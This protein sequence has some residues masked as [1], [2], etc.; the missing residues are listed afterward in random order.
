M[1]RVRQWWTLTRLIWWS[2][3]WHASKR[4]DRRRLY[5]RRLVTALAARVALFEEDIE[6]FSPVALSCWLGACLAARSGVRR[7]VG[8]SG[9]KARPFAKTSGIA[10]MAAY[11]A[12]RWMGRDA[13]AEMT[14]EG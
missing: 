7:P 9:R 14:L 10:V 11:Y 1:E 3:L 8:P 6:R 13:R 12:W 4:K 2:L 5:R